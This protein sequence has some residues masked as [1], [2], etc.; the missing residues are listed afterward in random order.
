[1]HQKYYI[2]KCYEYRVSIN[3]HNKE[4]R[5]VL[6]LELLYFAHVFISDRIT[7]HNKQIF[8]AFLFNTRNYS[9][10]V[11]N[12]QQLE[13]E[14]NIKLPRVNN[15]DIKQKRHG[16]FILFYASNAKQYNAKIKAHKISITI[17]LFFVQTELQ[18]LLVNELTFE[19]F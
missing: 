13:A 1:M 4:V 15:F 9:P 2:N 19:K 6:E 10:E 18:H 16:I 8:H 3:S 12:I 14:L 7:F 5:I 11:I 17:Q